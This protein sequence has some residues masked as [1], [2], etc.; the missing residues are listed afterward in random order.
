MKTRYF[1]WK[2]AKIVQR[3]GILSQTCDVLRKRNAFWTILQATLSVCVDFQ[4]RIA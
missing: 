1:S 2:I 4:S 3:W